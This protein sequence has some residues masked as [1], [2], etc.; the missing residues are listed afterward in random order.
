M[1]KPSDKGRLLQRRKQELDHALK[2]AYPLCGGASAGGANSERL[3]S[4]C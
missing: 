4:P 3:L 1:A 2:N